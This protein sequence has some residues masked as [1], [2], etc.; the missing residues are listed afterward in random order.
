MSDTHQ[1]TRYTAVCDCDGSDSETIVVCIEGQH[2]LTAEGFR[3]LDHDL[4]VF[5]M[6]DGKAQH[7]ENQSVA[8]EYIDL[9]RS[10][11]YMTESEIV[12]SE[13]QP[14][15]EDDPSGNTIWRLDVPGYGIIVIDPCGVVE[16]DEDLY[17]ISVAHPGDGAYLVVL[18]E[19]IDTDPLTFRDVDVED[20][21]LRD[22]VI[23]AYLVGIGAIEEAQDEDD[24]PDTNEELDN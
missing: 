14:T 8:Q 5:R 19:I 13:A 21:D 1:T 15:T 18:L 12:T 4:H 7:L 11:F 6:I 23:D 10:Y 16:H 9:V 2:D 3:V 22:G 20:S 17:Q 24:P